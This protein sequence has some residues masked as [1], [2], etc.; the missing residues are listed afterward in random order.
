MPPDEPSGRPAPGNPKRRAGSS[1]RLPLILPIIA[2]LLLVSRV[3]FGI[4]EHLNPPRTPDYVS[5]RPIESG[6]AEGR[7][8]NRPVLYD[9]TA[10]WCVPCV[11]MKKE[12]FADRAS[13]AQINKWVVPVRVLDQQR[14]LGENTAQVDSLQKLYGVTVFPTLVMVGPAGGEP[15]KLE[16]YPGKSKTMGWMTRSRMTLSTGTTSAP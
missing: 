12:I 13:S 2:G 16:G 5:W 3:G 9:F 7:A 15:Q 10:D 4:Y 6:S 1:R 14:E 8:D 11:R